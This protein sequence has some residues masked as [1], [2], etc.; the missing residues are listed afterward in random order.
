MYQYFK[1]LWFLF[2]EVRSDI[3][4]EALYQILL[5]NVRWRRMQDNP[6]DIIIYQRGD[7]LYAWANQRGSLDFMEELGQD[8]ERL[9]NIAILKYRLGNQKE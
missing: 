4:T 1:G 8:P 9:M 3:T 7:H 5:D 2:I 6:V